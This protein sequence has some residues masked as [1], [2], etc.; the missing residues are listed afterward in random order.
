[1]LRS[2]TRLPLHLALGTPVLNVRFARRLFDSR[3]GRQSV[4]DLIEAYFSL[5][6]MQIQ[7]SVV[8]QD[9]LRDAIAHPERH[10]DLI[11][12]VGGFSA[13]F[14]TLGEDLKRTILERTEHVL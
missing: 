6:G 2:V 1:M 14:N 11:V 4:R 10:E 3:Q 13:H 12:R 8:D 7:I 9:V 5:G